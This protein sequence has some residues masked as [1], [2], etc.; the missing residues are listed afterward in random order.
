MVT[1]DT[2]IGE[3]LIEW[4]RQVYCGLHGHDNLLHFEKERILLQCASCG[5]KTSGWD[6]NG[7]RPAVTTRAAS[8][9]RVFARPRLVSARRI[10]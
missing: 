3:R 4:M 7:T 10:A 1:A 2:G 5:H 8:R 6:L 9:A